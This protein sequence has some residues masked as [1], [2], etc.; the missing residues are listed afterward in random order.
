[1]RTY[2]QAIFCS[3]CFL[4]TVTTEWD[5]SQCA[6]ASVHLPFF[7]LTVSMEAC[8]WILIE[9]LRGLLICAPHSHSGPGVQPHTLLWG[10]KHQKIAPLLSLTKTKLVFVFLWFYC[11]TKDCAFEPKDHLGLEEPWVLIWNKLYDMHHQFTNK[12]TDT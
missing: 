4:S 7:H 11:V 1:M 2:R 6:T 5:I 9:V 10:P 3:L 12:E 8:L